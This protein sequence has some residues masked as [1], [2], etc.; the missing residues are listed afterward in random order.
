[1]I[2]TLELG[3]HEVKGKFGHVGIVIVKLTNLSTT[4]RT[5][6]ITRGGGDIALGAMVAGK[7]KETGNE[8]VRMKGIRD[9]GPDTGFVKE[10]LFEPG[11]EGVAKR[12]IHIRDELLEEVAVTQ[13]G[14]TKKPNEEVLNPVDKILSN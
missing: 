11:T 6:E 1:M 5:N 10:I 14:A 2:G 3:D 13:M 4:G 7:F 8:V 12:V 9:G